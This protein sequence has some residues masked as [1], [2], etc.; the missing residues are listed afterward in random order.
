M[1]DRKTAPELGFHTLG[2]HVENP[3]ARLGEELASA[4]RCCSR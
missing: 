2:G 3:R 4:R 1:T